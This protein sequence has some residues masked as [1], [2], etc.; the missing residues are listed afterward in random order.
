MSASDPDCGINSMVNFTLS[1]NSGPF[2]I[3]PATGEIC[4]AKSLDYETRGLYEFPVVATDRG[5]CDV[6]GTAASAI[7]FN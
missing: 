7:K 5:K 6:A 3:K 2:S 1:E 4:L